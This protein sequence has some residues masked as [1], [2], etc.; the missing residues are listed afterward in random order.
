MS[1]H[2]EKMVTTAEWERRWKARW[3]A[4]EKPRYEVGH[5]LDNERSFLQGTNRKLSTEYQQLS[6]LIAEFERGVCDLFELGP[7][8]TVFGSAR[9]KEGHPYYA[10]AV[11]TA[12]CS[13]RPASRS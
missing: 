7:A 8:V 13:L 5:P 4:G 11:E 3:A 2:S 12:A 6:Q 9:F 10:I 1:G